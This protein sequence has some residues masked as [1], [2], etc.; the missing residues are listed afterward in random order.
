MCVL[1]VGRQENAPYSESMPVLR[2][3]CVPG[4]GTTEGLQNMVPNTGAP[5]VHHSAHLKGHQ[6]A[7]PLDPEQRRDQS[8]EMRHIAS[9]D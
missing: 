3:D 8:T 2:A 1:T 4:A 7:I 6:C 5:Q 9:N